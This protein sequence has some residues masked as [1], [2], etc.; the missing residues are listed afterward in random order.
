MSGFPGG[1]VV[2]T[3]PANAVDNGLHPWFRKIP[4]APEQLSPGTPQP[5]S[6]CS[7]AQELQLLSLH[8]LEPMLNSKRSHVRS[9]KLAHHN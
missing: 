1:S 2:E 6:L 5:L 9:E 8:S 7:R 3:P 4:H